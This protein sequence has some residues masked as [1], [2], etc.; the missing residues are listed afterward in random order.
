MATTL[1]QE[2]DRAEVVVEKEADS[3]EESPRAKK[4]RIGWC[5]RFEADEWYCKC[6]RK[7]K[8]L[9]VTRKTRN[10]GRLFWM[11]PVREPKQ[12]GDPEPCQ[13][14]MWDDEQDTAIEWME[15]N[16]TT[17]AK[18]P[19][20]KSR[21]IRTPNNGSKKCMNGWLSGTNGKKRVIQDISD[22]DPQ[23]DVENKEDDF[24]IVENNDIEDV[25]NPENTRNGSPSRKSAKV[26]RFTT[27]GQ[28]VNKNMEDGRNELP[29]PATTGRAVD[30]TRQPYVREASPTPI[31]LDAAINLGD[32]RE[33]SEGKTDLLRSILA[34]IKADYP[35]LKASTEIMIEHEI[36]QE[37]RRTRAEAKGYRK[38][39]ARLRQTV[40][41]LETTVSH[42]TYGGAADDVVVLSD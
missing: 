20:P 39:I 14:F 4:Q 8:R 35:D 34:L 40:D 1:E 15:L 19:A 41:D 31:Q 25:F 13:F 38:T 2:E 12:P 16:P 30:G 5:G 24:V 17:P 26:T 7:A 42:L 21:E 18:Q 3:E 33:P 10:E 27:P 36:E 29:T 23:E 6:D 11:C 28:P 37:V 9:P 32:A 22:D